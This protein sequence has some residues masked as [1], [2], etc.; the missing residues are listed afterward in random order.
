MRQSIQYSSYLQAPVANPLTCFGRCKSNGWIPGS[1]FLLSFYHI[2][3]FPTTAPM[4]IHS[5]PPSC[6]ASTK[7]NIH[8]FSAVFQPPPRLM[9]YPSTQRRLGRLL[10]PSSYSPFTFFASWLILTGS[11]AAFPFPLTSGCSSPV[12]SSLVKLFCGFGAASSL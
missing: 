3:P 5:Q 10:R 12:P 4:I 7:T 2:F 11:D 8:G 9:S 1:W 6:F